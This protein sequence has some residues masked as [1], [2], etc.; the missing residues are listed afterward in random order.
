MDTAASAAIVMTPVDS[1]HLSFLAGIVII[2]CLWLLGCTPRGLL[3]KTDHALRREYPKRREQQLGGKQVCEGF[4][5]RFQRIIDATIAINHSATSR[6][7]V[8]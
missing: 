2:V 8:P 1:G 3:L 4:V 5:S 6:G 7:S